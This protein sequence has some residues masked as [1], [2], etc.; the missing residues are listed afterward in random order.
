MGKKFVEK[1]I[2][3]EVYIFHM[4]RPRISVA[5]LSKIVRLL[6]PSLGKAFPNEV[7]IK[8]IFDVNINIG[9][10]IITFSDKFDDIRVQEMIDVLFSQIQHK[11]EGALSDDTVY[12]KLFAGRIKHLFKVV[13]K[14][15]EVQYADF[16]E[17]KDFLAMMLQKSKEVDM[18]SQLTL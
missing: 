9:D 2:D 4:L 8:E 18:K 12:D 16:L 17:G 6:G 7:K 11:G 13:F 1:E 3:G 15:M 10:A 5:L 14:A